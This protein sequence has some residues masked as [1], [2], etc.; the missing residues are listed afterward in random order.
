MKSSQN[1][2]ISSGSD[3]VEEILLVTTFVLDGI[4]EFG[5]EPSGVFSLVPFDVSFA[6]I[7]GDSSKFESTSGMGLIGRWK[8]I[9]LIEQMYAN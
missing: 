5:T 3:G 6:S 2:R 7:P 4:M 1:Y 9:L 8:W